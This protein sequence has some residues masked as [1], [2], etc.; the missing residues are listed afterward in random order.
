MK[1]KINS[2][3]H[4]SHTDIRFDSR[5]LK[6]LVCLSD[7][8][9]FQVIGIGFEL[10][11]GATKPNRKYPFKIKTFRLISRIKLIPRV[12]RYTLNFIELTTYLVFQGFKY[13]PKIVHCHDTLVLPAGAII[14]FF[15]SSKLVYDAHEL[16]SNKNG[17]SRVLSV[18]TFLIEKLF[19]NNINLFISV[20]DSIIN[21]Y[22]ERFSKKKSVLILNSPEIGIKKSQNVRTIYKDK[23]FHRKYQI[24]KGEKIFIYLGILS[25]EGRGVD[26]ILN[27]FSSRNINGHIVFIGYGSMRKKIEEFSELYSNIH[28]HPPVAHSLVVEI[29]QN[30]DVGLCLI[31]N[32]SLSDY[33]SLPNK[34]FE[35]AFSGLRVVGSKFPEIE[36]VIDEYSLGKTCNLDETSLENAL[37][38]VINKPDMKKHK[39]IKNLSWGCQAEKL[40]NAYREMLS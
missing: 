16:E 23:Y 30:A 22:M 1:H 11:E 24:P 18:S 38:E 6:E 17:Q 15:H 8:K 9:L 28:Y 20:S 36:Y 10:D 19:W 7:L 12:I 25:K 26:L 33:Y 13:K 29:S 4:I 14:K 31:E 21:W 35:Y 3:L 40:I 32:V 5:I 39:N 34:L 27:V 2:I 37:N